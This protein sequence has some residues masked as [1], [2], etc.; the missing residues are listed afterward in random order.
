MDTF[1]GWLTGDARL[2]SLISRLRLLENFYDLPGDQYNRLFDE[3]L[4]KLMDRIPDMRK[5]LA[6]LKRFNWTGYVAAAVRGSGMSDHRAVQEVT[7]DIVSKLLLGKLFIGYDPMQHGPFVNRFK[8]SVGNAVRNVVEKQR[9]RRRNIPT[10]SISNEFRPGGVTAN[11]VAASQ[12][13]DDEQA[14]EY[15]RR[16]VR[17]RLGELALAV[18]DL[19]LDGGDTKSLVGDDELG[20]PSSYRVK[21]TVRDIKDLAKEFAAGRDPGFLEMFARAMAGEERRVRKRFAG[22]GD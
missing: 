18:L 12:K 21:Q 16:L 19:R 5:E 1:F 22:Q 20:R 4:K 6:A 17:D 13:P 2:G 3:E 15:F 8:R 14:I 9:N 10:V 11:D 7:H